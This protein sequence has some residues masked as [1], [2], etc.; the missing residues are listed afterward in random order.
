MDVC[1]VHNSRL[2]Y[3]IIGE[4]IMQMRVCFPIL[5]YANCRSY[6]LVSTLFISSGITV[7]ELT[8]NIQLTEGGSVS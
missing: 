2:Q 5:Y 3:G 4:Y 6:L 7:C 1:P 8:V